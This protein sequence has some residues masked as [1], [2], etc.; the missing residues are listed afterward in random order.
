MFISPLIALKKTAKQVAL[1][2]LQSLGQEDRPDPTDHRFKLS[3]NLELHSIPHEAPTPRNSQA[4]LI[5]A[6]STGEIALP[7]LT[8]VDED[9]SSETKANSPIDEDDEDESSEVD[10]RDGITINNYGNNINSPPPP[11]RNHNSIS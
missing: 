7:A 8:E 10:N 3:E 2:S 6:P 11:P 1:T 9:N 4:S 5:Q